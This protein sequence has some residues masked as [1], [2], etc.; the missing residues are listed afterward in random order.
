MTTDSSSN[1]SSPV[2]TGVKNPG[3]KL[4][5]TK[6]PAC[7]TFKVQPGYSRTNPPP[8]P[9][10]PPPCWSATPLSRNSHRTATPLAL[11][12]GPTGHA[13][14]L[15]VVIPCVGS[16]LKIGNDIGETFVGGSNL[17]PCLNPKANNCRRPTAFSNVQ[18]LETIMDTGTEFKLHDATDDKNSDTT[19]LNW[20]D[21]L[22]HSFKKL[23]LD[24]IF[25]IPNTRWTSETY[26]LEDWGKATL[27]FVEP[28]V[29]QLE[30]GIFDP[31][32]GGTRFLPCQYDIKNL[33]YSS[34]FILNSLTP[35]YKQLVIKDLGHGVPGPTILSH[36][37]LARITLQSTKQCEYVEALCSVCL[38]AFPGEDVRLMNHK[39]SE[40]CK[41]IEQTGHLP[42]DLSLL[43]IQCYTCSQV[44]QF[45][46]LMW[47]Y[48][49]KLLTNATA[50]TWNKITKEGMRNYLLLQNYWHPNGKSTTANPVT[51]RNEF[52]NYVKKTDEHIEQLDDQF[53]QFNAL[54]LQGTRTDT[55]TDNGT[56]PFCFDC[57]KKEL[58]GVTKVVLP[59][60]LETS[61]LSRTRINNH[62]NIPLLK[63]RLRMA[64][65]SYIARSA[66]R[67]SKMDGR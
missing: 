12:F 38:T 10:G 11:N 40:L 67:R 39:I 33:E 61:I 41:G 48:E 1:H 31:R 21:E 23:G 26:I 18:K 54:K 50:Y 27:E 19:L 66:S 65:P 57:N 55:N 45:Y 59:L 62:I 15:H 3:R 24:T 52:A 37:L 4:P 49:A 60:D 7:T 36:L 58:R 8:P 25:R 13:Y 51:T 16:V 30:S 32:H 56:E 53:K 35:A 43:I 6:T 5:V 14:H 9:P 47:A 20:L 42:H 2:P 34:T 46:D 44:T 29:A 28:W 63:R 17:T 64:S 22:A